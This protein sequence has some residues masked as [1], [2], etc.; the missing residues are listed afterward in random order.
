M[1]R[2]P[3]NCAREVR[4]C[5]LVVAL[6]AA[7]GIA[8]G[9]TPPV[10]PCDG[11][12]VTSIDITPRD[13]S[14]LA[15]PKRLRRVARGV[16]LVHTTSTRETID[17]FLLL[18]VGQP[19]SERKRAE[20][21]RILRLQ[22]FLA[23]ATVRAVS[24]DAGGV[25]I[26]VETVDEIPTVLDMRFRDRRPSQIR[27]GNGNV[28]GQGL[29]LAASVQRGLAYRTG[30]GIHGVAYQ[31][32]GQPYTLALVAERS[33]LGGE[34]TLAFG[35]AFFTDLQRSA[36]HVGVSDVDRYVTFSAPE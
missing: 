29:Y 6:F 13:P 16:G 1:R 26:D 15:V 10:L 5:S 21:E 8:K 33:P 32:L 17:R 36:W 2:C 24:D 34:L 23:D 14:F 35:H 7:P 18:D 9:S 19:C 4:A 22:P 28:R 11:K 31:V 30:F 20:S 3:E 27:F 25:R 12:V